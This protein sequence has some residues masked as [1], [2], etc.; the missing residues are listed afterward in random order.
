MIRLSDGEIVEDRR[1]REVHE[2]PPAVAQQKS[3]HPAADAGL[4]QA[5]P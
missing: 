4:A 5:Q 1:S 3:A 2:A